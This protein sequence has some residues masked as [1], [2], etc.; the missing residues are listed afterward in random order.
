MKEEGVSLPPEKGM[1]PGK[2][3]T[4]RRS[5]FLHEGGEGAIGVEG[6]PVFSGYYQ[7]EKGCQVRA[8]YDLCRGGGK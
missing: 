3:E 6:G 4:R 2:R 5:L 8:E 1:L 7:K